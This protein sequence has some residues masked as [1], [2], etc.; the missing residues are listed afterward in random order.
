MKNVLLF[1][2]T[3]LATAINAQDMTIPYAQISDYPESYTPQNV[4]SR[5]IDGLGYRLYWATEGLSAH[6][7]TYKPEGKDTKSIDETMDHMYM[8]ALTIKN[9]CHHLPNE[10]PANVPE[11]DYNQKREAILNML[12]DAS[13]FLRQ[14]DKPLDTLQIIFKRGERS[15]EFPFWNLIN[16][17]ISD[18]IYHTGQIVSYRRSAGNPMDP[19]VNV[20]MGKN[21]VPR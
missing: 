14:T 20:F 21:R 9:V 4:A 15:S 19:M 10:R 5:M 18:A 11:M 13:S 7:V 2:F 3:L 6:E 1:I 17:Q 16:G 12:H 8:L